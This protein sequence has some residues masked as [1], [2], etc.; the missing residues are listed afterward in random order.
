[1]KESKLK[2]FF[3]AIHGV[4]AGLYNAT[5][6]FVLHSFK[7]INGKVRSKLPVWRM[8][9]ETL[10]HVHSAM[11]IFKWI[12]LPASLLYSFITFYFFRENALDSALWGMLLFF[13]SNFLPDLPSIYRKKKKN[14]GKSEDLSWYK[15]YAILLFAPLLIWL[16]FS[17]TQLAW[18]TTETFHN[19]KSLT[20]YS[21]FLLL[22]GVFAYA[23]FP[24]E[25]V[26]LIKIASIPIYG[27]IGYLTHLKVDKIW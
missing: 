2:R 9:E 25:I 4:M 6:G 1:M 7:S 15:K 14:N 23:S 8:E 19:F 16:L 11:R 24:I 3:K 17:G 13:Y 26:N 12:V 21:I 20:I 22:L 5:Y 18:R 10:E 27:I